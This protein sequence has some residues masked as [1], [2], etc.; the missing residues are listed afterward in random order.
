MVPLQQTGRKEKRRQ[1]YLFHV[2]EQP[3]VSLQQMSALLPGKQE[4]EQE[5]V[6]LYSKNQ[7]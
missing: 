3:P 6:S 7:S 1:A 5:K 4:E 2:K